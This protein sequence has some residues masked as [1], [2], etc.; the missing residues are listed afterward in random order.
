MQKIFELPMRDDEAGDISHQSRDPILMAK[1]IYEMDKV[2]S[3][4]NFHKQHLFGNQAAY[5]DLPISS[6]NFK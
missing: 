4:S 1:K 3:R 5:P 6:R 2:N